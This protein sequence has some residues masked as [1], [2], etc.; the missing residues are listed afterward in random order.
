MAPA[1]SVS[2]VLKAAWTVMIRGKD[3]NDP[4]LRPIYDEMRR[5]YTRAH[6][7]EQTWK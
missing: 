7:V 2:E 3:L 4:G 1:I 5:L 6:E